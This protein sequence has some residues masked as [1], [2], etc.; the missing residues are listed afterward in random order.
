MTGDKFLFQERPNSNHI[1]LV[2]LRQEASPQI[3]QFNLP[4]NLVGGQIGTF[5]SKSQKRLVVPQ[6]DGTGV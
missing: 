6:D 4:F 5:Y 1:W 3:H 2:H